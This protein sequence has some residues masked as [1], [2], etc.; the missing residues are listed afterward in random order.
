MPGAVFLARCVFTGV[1]GV[2]GVKGERGGPSPG[3][4]RIDDFDPESS[5][6]GRTQ[7]QVV[8]VPDEAA[9]SGL[10]L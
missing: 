8:Q 5:G 1:L 10:D 3:E 6:L 2:G 9:Y 4:V 7:P